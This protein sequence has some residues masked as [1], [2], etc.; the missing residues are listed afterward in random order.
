MKFVGKIL[1]KWLAALLDLSDRISGYGPRILSP[2]D[3]LSRGQVLVR[4]GD[5]ET[6]LAIGRSTPFQQ[7]SPA[8]SRELRQ[9]VALRDPRMTL[10]FPGFLLRPSPFTRAT[11]R[12]RQIWLLT[13]ILMRLQARRGPYGDALMFRIDGE[14]TGLNAL[15]SQIRSARRITLVSS[16]PSHVRTL[17]ALQP[18][19]AIRHVLVPREQAY[20]KR[21]EIRFEIVEQGEPDLLL[22]SAGPVGKC[23]APELMAKWRQTKIIDTGH[24]FGHAIEIA[25]EPKE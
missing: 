4:W 16:D 17:S 8:L 7:P 1:L 11:D 12:F 5:G 6:S 14:M 13:V 22:L 20:E 19:G 2:G 15:R 3:A 23:L 24:F 9:L 18:A 10:C 21:E 25:G